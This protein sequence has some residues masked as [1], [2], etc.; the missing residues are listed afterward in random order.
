LKIRVISSK[1][2][3]ATLENEEMVHIAFR[4]SDT[5]ILTL[6]KTCPKLKGIHI[7]ISYKN[8]ISKTTLMFL[9][10]Q[11]IKLLEGDVW[12]HR[13]DISA[14]Y[15]IKPQIL[16]RIKELKKE[17]K[18]KEEMVSKL[19]TETRLSKDLLEFLV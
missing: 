9:E 7:P 1:D 15:E 16:D 4:P 12:G 6:I 19:G 8:T 2:K 17:G 10:M 3:I 13:T 5:D 14:Y 18:S 11:G